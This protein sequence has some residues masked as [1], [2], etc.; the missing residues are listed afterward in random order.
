[1]AY[2]SGTVQWGVYLLHVHSS[3]WVPLTDLD[4]PLSMDRSDTMAYMDAMSTVG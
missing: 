4:L 3:S 2:V 1:M